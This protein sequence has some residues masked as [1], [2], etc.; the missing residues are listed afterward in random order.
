MRDLPDAPGDH[1]RLPDF[2]SLPVLFA[3]LLVSGLTVTVML[4][5]PGSALD[6][7]G[8]STAALFAVWLAL[9]VAVTLCKLRR[10]L[11]RLHGLLPFA[12]V[13]LVMVAIVVVASAG[14][15]WLDHALDMMLTPA[16]A[17]RFVAGNGA[18][19]ALI[20]AAV[21]RFFYVVAQ[22]QARLAAVSR[23]QVQALQ[24]RIRPHFLFNSMNTVAALV[25]VDPA[26]AE[27]TIEDLSELFRAALG[28]EGEGT[29]GEELALVDRYLA[30]E[31][32]R[33]GERL[34][35]ERDLDALPR[36]LPLP[37]LLLQPL[38]ENAVRHGIQPS[39]E[40][41]TVSLRGR[42]VDD[43]VEIIVANPLPAAPVGTQRGHGHGLDSVRQRIGYHFGA[44]GSLQTTPTDDRF[45]VTVRLPC[46]AT[47]EP[48][49]D[50][51]GGNAPP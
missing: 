49:A 3:L 35:V 9:L 13:W 17:I 26:A 14:V 15:W 36:A 47:S 25:R 33:L 12:G 18:V 1:E 7:A 37:R 10:W 22:W 11:L 4:L 39:R 23:A 50:L 42:R 38:V 5:A 6:L 34:R 30:I 19:A 46:A 43:M 31:Q 29:L 41:G 51:P 20:G 28:G 27:R 2:C 44:R 45:V 40:G 24:A 32:L 21:L 48:R 16:S 8:F